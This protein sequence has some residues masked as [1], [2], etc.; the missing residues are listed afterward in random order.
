MVTK[1]LRGSA[2]FSTPLRPGELFF[3]SEVRPFNFPVSSTLLP[4][5]FPRTSYALFTA[6]F[7]RKVSFFRKYYPPPT[8]GMFE[9]ESVLSQ[10]ASIF[11]ASLS[12]GLY[13][14]HR[15]RNSLI[16]LTRPRRPFHSLFPST[17]FKSPNGCFS[18]ALPL[19]LVLS[20]RPHIHVGALFPF[21]FR[22]LGESATDAPPDTFF[23]LTSRETIETALPLPFRFPCVAFARRISR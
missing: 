11:P 10:L 16:P 12:Q 1:G 20:M 18:P 8:L 21:P 9:G 7:L 4:P 22:S 13:I 17:F 6:F 14:F 3:E 23:F 5:L 15:L 2:A 19:F